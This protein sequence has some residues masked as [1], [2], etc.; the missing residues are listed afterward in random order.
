V[1]KLKPLTIV[2]ALG[3][4]LPAFGQVSEYAVKAAYLFN[5]AKFVEWPKGTFGGNTEPIL[6][7]VLGEDPFGEDLDR[8]I[9]GKS[10]NGH[11]I[12]LKRFGVFDGIQISQVIR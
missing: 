2:L 12:R 10:V 11:T 6:I 3:L 8:T 5:F 7:G 1:K 9:D 4:V